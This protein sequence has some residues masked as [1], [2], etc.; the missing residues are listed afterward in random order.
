MTNKKPITFEQACKIMQ[1]T[2]TPL[3]DT[4][5]VAIESALGRTLAE[6]IRANID[7]PPYRNSAM[8]GYALNSNELAPTKQH[9]LNIAGTAYAG[10]PYQGQIKKGECVRI[11]TGALLP[12]T[13]DAVIIQENTRIEDGSILFEQ[14]IESGQNVRE[15]G[16]DY[17]AGDIALHQRQR[18]S[19]ADLGVLAALGHATVKVLRPVRVIYFTSG[20]ELVTPDTSLATSLA[21]GQ[22]FNSNRYA[23]EALLQR[24][25]IEASYGGNLPDSPDT[26]KKRLTEASNEADVIITC[27]AVSVGDADHI[28]Q[29]LTTTGEVY[30]SKVAIKPG[31]PLH[32][33][34]FHNS[35]FFG[36][37]GNPISAMVT[38]L[39]LLQPA[40]WQ[41]AGA[42][43]LAA[44][45][46]PAILE[47]PLRKRPGRLE[48]QRGTLNPTPEGGM[49]VRST[50]PQGSHLLSSI[51]RADCF[52]I[53]PSESADIAAG[54][55]VQTIPFTEVYGY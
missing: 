29:M 39:T 51:S 45:Q 27:G 24:G 55:P 30:F 8:D 5:S 9:Q 33:A 21:P 43:W 47:T 17:K 48:F 40:L 31:K 4:E 11:M 6:D 52:I 14:N 15:A 41:L 18:L 26:V 1:E 20:D 16:E 50:G 34:R 12:A 49:R 13:T 36:L 22:L 44:R 35:W 23:L 38:Y 54:E 46:W 2:I 32:F 53:L 3:S 7:L 42:G 19:P 28:G 37:P 25:G 10:Q